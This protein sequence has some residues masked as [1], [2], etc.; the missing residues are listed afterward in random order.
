MSRG[1]LYSCGEGIMSSSGVGVP[2]T[3]SL[4]DP[5]VIQNRASLELRQILSVPLQLWLG[6]WESSRVALGG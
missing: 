3:L 2:L 5:L 4:G 1:L 6:S